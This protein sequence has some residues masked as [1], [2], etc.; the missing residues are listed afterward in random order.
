[1][2]AT[3]TARKYNDPTWWN[4]DY[5]SGWDRVKEA[6]RRDWDQTK[7][8]FGGDE[9]DLNQRRLIGQDT[10]RA[11]HDRADCVVNSV[12][13]HSA[14]ARPRGVR[15]E[16]QV[17]GQKEEREREDAVVEMKVDRQRA[18]KRGEPLEAKQHAR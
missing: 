1:M 6:F 8:D 11:Q 17:R 5:D 3:A 9:P 16:D 7:H 15:R 14:D 10:H 13:G 12:V 2:A 4:R 18:A